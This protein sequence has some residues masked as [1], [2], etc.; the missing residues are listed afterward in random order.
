[1]FN[2]LIDKLLSRQVVS[3]FDRNSQKDLKAF[4][5]AAEWWSIKRQQSLFTMG[6]FT[7]VGTH[8][9]WRLLKHYASSDKECTPRLKEGNKYGYRPG[10]LWEPRFAL[11]DILML[12]DVR[13]HLKQFVTVL[14][15]IARQAAVAKWGLP[16]ENSDAT[17]A[18]ATVTS[19]PKLQSVVYSPNY[20]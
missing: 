17:I 5:F 6:I 10:T 15:S 7:V 12:L 16:D 1:M 11:D 18:D 20:P 3:R 9:D 19:R 8:R 4:R 14:F 13:I 2:Y